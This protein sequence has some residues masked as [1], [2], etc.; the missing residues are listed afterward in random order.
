MIV[1]ISLESSELLNYALFGV[2]LLHLLDVTLVDQIG[3]SY[4]E[5]LRDGRW[6]SLNSQSDRNWAK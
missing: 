6:V 4:L 5:K 2:G 1:I 3:K